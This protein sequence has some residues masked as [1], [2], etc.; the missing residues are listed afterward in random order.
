MPVK[1]E[2]S[3][4]TLPD[5]LRSRLDVVFIGINPSL[6]S[7]AQGHYFARRTNRFWPCFSRSRLSEAARRG[8]SLERLEPAHDHALLAHGFGFTDVAKR[9]SARA[10]QL[11]PA[12]LTEGVAELARK[13]ERFQPRI[14]CFHGLTGYRPFHRRFFPTHAEPCLGMQSPVVGVTRLFVVPNPSP[15]NAHFTPAD[16]TRW[17]DALA[18]CLAELPEASTIG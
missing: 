12:E 16:Q 13:L 11:A 17:Y 10:A 9:P 1:I 18:A 5:L 6:Y 15:A 7:A 4:P 3:L 2:A 8:L 14:A